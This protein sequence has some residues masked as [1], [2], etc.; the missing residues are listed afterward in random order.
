MI[1]S[2]SGAAPYPVG[3]S[4]TQ[5]VT[6]HPT[7]WGEG[8]NAVTGSL[9]G[10]SRT[11]VIAV[12]IFEFQLRPIFLNVSEK[13]NAA[14]EPAETEATATV[15]LENEAEET[16]I[17]RGPGNQATADGSSSGAVIPVSGAFLVLGFLTLAIAMSM[18]I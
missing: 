17:D 2:F 4:E 5:T 15:D 6:T 18:V 8:F 12:P 9:A 11:R 16:A 1:T 13:R 3:G 14:S 10:M 7:C